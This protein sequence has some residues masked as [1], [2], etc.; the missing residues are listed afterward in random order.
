MTLAAAASACPGFCR[1]SYGLSEAGAQQAN[2]ASSAIVNPVYRPLFFTPKQYRTIE[3]LA[4]L[5]LP[6]I[7]DGEGKQQPGAREAGVAEFIDFMVASDPSLQPQFRDGLT[8]LDHASMPA[9]TFAGLEPQQ[10]TALL[11]RLAY[12]ARYKESEQ[13]GQHFFKLVR[14]YTV[15]GFYTSKIGLESLDYP[16]LTFYATSPGC[17]HA[18]NPEHT[19]L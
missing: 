17:T 7:Q 10:Q 1:W 14:R 5:I 8:W 15:M 9:G 3:V 4:E 11:E 19:G 2:G 12:K 18:G 16:G 6:S 13:A